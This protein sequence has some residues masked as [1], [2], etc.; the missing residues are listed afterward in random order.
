MAVD[1]AKKLNLHGGCLQYSPKRKICYIPSTYQLK[2]EKIYDFS[3]YIHWIILNL[4]QEA[5]WSG[6]NSRF[7]LPAAEK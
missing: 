5:V 7:Q 3:R 1:Y 4:S 6:F 2:R